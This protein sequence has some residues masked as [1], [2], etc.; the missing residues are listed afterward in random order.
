[1]RFWRSSS[2][3]P[4]TDF[5]FLE[6]IAK[7]SVLIDAQ[8]RVV[9]AN[10][11][12]SEMCG[13]WGT[14]LC[15]IALE[16]ILNATP[17]SGTLPL[18]SYKSISHDMHL[19]DTAFRLLCLEVPKEH[20]ND[21]ILEQAIDAVVS[22][23]ANNDV[24]FFNKAAEE[25][26]KVSRDEILGKN[27]KRLVPQAMRSGHDDMVNHNRRTGENRIVGTMRE[28]QI[29]RFDGTQATVGLTLSKVHTEEGIC[30]TAFLKDIS[31]IKIAERRLRETLEQ[32]LDAVVEI[33]AQNNVVFFNPAAERLWGYSRDEVMGRNVDMLVPTTH[34][35]Q[36]DDLV[37][38]N[39]RTGINRIVGT[40][41]E[42][43][44]VRKDGEK[45]WV[46]LSLSKVP[47]E[48]GTITYTAFLRD[49]TEEVGRREHIRLLSLVADETD[50]AVLITG[51]DRKLIYVNS[52][53]TRLTGYKPEEVM[54]RKPGEFLQGPETDPETVKRISKA[55]SSGN[56][57]YEEI[58]NYDRSGKPY[59]ISLAV[60]PVFDKNGKIEKFISIQAN[61]SSIKLTS[62]EYTRQLEA[63]SQTAAMAE[64][65]ADG[66]SIKANAYLTTHLDGQPLPGLLELLEAEKLDK[67]KET[68]EC[69]QDIVFARTDGT[70]SIFDAYF[71]TLT[72]ISGD[73]QKY[74]MYGPDITSRAQAVKDTN[75]AV[76]DVTASSQEISQVVETID[77]IAMQTNLLALNASVE[78]ARAGD[79]G[80]G[81]AVVAGE[82]RA[83]A[84]RAR[85]AAEQVN[86]KIAATRDRVGRLAETI[87]RLKE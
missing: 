47:R 1:M 5:S 54:G 48:D 77:S 3:K 16:D 37:N 4:S 66:R 85:E 9:Y 87:N 6:H 20:Q 28:V 83:L 8:G 68:G 69:R 71:L 56:P 22:I 86:A 51:A 27:V 43:L 14:E 64:W 33:D 63:I 67:L 75:D 11:Y 44:L 18:S 13:K 82:V 65:N 42:V 70:Q 17:A 41:R 55:L 21:A 50:N 81:F 59:W 32:A 60:N 2:F 38:H 84:V 53:F 35:A 78:A 79:A 24:V 52:G 80:R 76:R 74:L 49:V 23:D 15:E 40:S 7:P 61:I 25:L 10:A 26:W 62:L 57:F 72:D 73:V 31:G 19:G 58:L 30:Y 34:R 29:E 12:F 36:H 39:R 45:R 46:N